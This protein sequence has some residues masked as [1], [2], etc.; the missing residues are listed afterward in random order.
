[1][2]L[3]AAQMREA[4]AVATQYI[5]EQVEDIFA[6]RNALYGRMVKRKKAVTEGKTEIQMPITYAENQSVGFIAGDGSDTISLNPNKTITFGTLQWKYFYSNISIS[7]QDIVEGGDSKESVITLVQ[8]KVS[9]AK[10]TMARNLSEAMYASATSNAKTFNGMA[11]IFAASGTA[12]AGINNNDVPNWFPLE[13]SSTQIINYANINN[14]LA[15]LNVRVGQSPF[16]GYGNDLKVDLLLSN[17]FVQSQY[18]NSE[19]I[20]Q[21]YIESKKLDSGFDGIMFNGIEWAVDYYAPGSANGTT[22]D[23][24]LYMLSTQAFYLFYRY[25]FDRPAPL[26]TS[27]VIPN[28]PVQFDVN[29]L[30][31]NMGCT[32]RRVNALMSTLKA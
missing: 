12:Y 26:D 29:Y 13:D 6:Q 16:D 14:N 3:S 5:N 2:A 28:T 30:V 18:M 8:A 20:K 21:R 11:D 15:Q 32:N 17:W 9:Q 10:N 22:A 7:L 4:G 1:M 24:Y 19:Q 31:A 27:G 23:N 25:G